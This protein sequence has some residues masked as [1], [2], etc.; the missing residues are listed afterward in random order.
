M[1]SE[2]ILHIFLEKIGLE[3]REH[4]DLTFLTV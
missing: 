1:V 3:S 4:V 2:G